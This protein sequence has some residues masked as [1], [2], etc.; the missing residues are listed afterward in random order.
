MVIFS[1]GFI[2]GELVDGSDDAPYGGLSIRPVVYLKSSVK[3]TGGTGTISDP[4]TLG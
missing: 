1:N 2:V 4:Y 3:I